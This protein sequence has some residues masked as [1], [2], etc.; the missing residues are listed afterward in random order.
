MS[1]QVIKIIG[2][3]NGM[4]NTPFDG[5]YL[6]EYDPSRTGHDPEG[7]PMLASVEVTYYVE[8]A[9]RFED[10]LEAWEYWK[11]IDKREPVRSDGHPNRPLTAFTIE[12]LPLTLANA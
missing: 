4:F 5:M 2:L 10:K 3:A 8:E 12:V 9:K 6:K 11:Q 1:A 7:R